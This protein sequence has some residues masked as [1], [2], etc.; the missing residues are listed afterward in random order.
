MAAQHPFTRTNPLPASRLLS[1]LRNS[2]PLR[3]LFLLAGCFLL[4]SLAAQPGRATEWYVDASVSASGD[5][6]SWETAFQTIQEGIT[7]AGHGSTVIVARGTYYENIRFQ[8]K[9]IVLRSLDPCDAD[10]V[11]NTIIDG[12]QAGPVV[13]FGSWSGASEGESCVLAGRK[14]NGHRVSSP[15]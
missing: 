13:Q 3:A 14:A 15:T 4:L 1:H 6:T 9:N 11:T 2:L 7:R 10:V 5:G 8:G 12:G